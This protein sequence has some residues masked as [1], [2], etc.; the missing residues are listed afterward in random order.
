M[1][2]PWCPRHERMTPAGRLVEVAEFMLAGIP[3]WME[4]KVAKTLGVQHV[5]CRICGAPREGPEDA[6]WAERLALSLI[7]EPD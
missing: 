1:S 3:L 6:E 4:D 7:W 2:T 5:G